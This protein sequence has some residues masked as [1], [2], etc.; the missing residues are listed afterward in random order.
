MA[1]LPVV[2]GAKVVRAFERAGWRQDRQRG[3]HVVLLK[4]G[5]NASL[6]VPNT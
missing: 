4:T 2:S 1:G 6:S 3:S 5:H